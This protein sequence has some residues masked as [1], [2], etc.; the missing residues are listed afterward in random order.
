MKYEDIISQF[1][2][3]P[4]P[5]GGHFLESYR[6]EGTVIK[7]SLPSNMEGLS[8]SYSTGIYFLLP[9]GEKSNFHRIKSDEMWHF[10]LGGPM[11]VV[12]IHDSGE[13]KETILGQNINKGELVQYVVPANCW[14][15]SYPLEGS[16]YS[17]VGCT[18]APG[19]D[20]Q[21]FKLASTDEL[22]NLFPQH[23]EVIKKLT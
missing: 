7:E 16:D 21:D 11:C 9:Q 10:Y 6:S 12:E 15:G 8:R 17:F 3:K 2:L 19:F 22:L 13:I 1:N 14:F 4:H 5:E 20:F 23:E 18:V